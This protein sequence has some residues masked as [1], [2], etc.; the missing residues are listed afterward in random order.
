[1][2]FPFSSIYFT[3]CSTA[4]VITRPAYQ[5]AESETFMKGE[6]IKVGVYKVICLAV[7]GHGYMLLLF[8]DAVKAGL[9]II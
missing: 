6:K 3:H 7:K 2:S 5:V 9:S 4:R 1:M 8:C